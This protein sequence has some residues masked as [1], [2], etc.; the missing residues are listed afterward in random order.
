M[1][2]ITQKQ[3]R[4]LLIEDNPGDARL[5][6]EALEE[7]NSALYH[8]VHVDR[9]SLALETLSKEEIDVALVDLSLPDS[10]G[11]ETVVKIHA[12]ASSVPIVVLTSLDDEST[13]V[14]AVKK[15]A[16]DYLI[17]GEVESH[18]LVRSIRYAMER[19]RIQKQSLDHA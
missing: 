5:L 6:K 18:S 17:K 11:I 7:A 9:L 14:E 15:G 16:Q 1:T 12:H 2:K 13:A 4:V 10:R 8:L 19:C 3:I